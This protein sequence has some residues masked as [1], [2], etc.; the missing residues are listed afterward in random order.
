M[1]NNKINLLTA[2]IV[3]DATHHLN[4][5]PMP[6]FD[7]TIH[8]WISKT[9][10]MGIG[11][12]N[13]QLYNYNYQLAN[14]TQRYEE[15]GEA[16]EPREM[17]EPN[18]YVQF[19][20]LAGPCLDVLK[21]YLSNYGGYRRRQLASWHQGREEADYAP[22]LYP[23]TM[24][25]IK[26][27]S[28]ESGDIEI[29]SQYGEE[30]LN[31]FDGA[32]DLTDL[33][34]PLTLNLIPEIAKRR[35][36]NARINRYEDYEKAE[37]KID[38]FG[39]FSCFGSSLD[40]EIFLQKA[41]TDNCK[42]IHLD[43][44]Y[45]GGSSKVEASLKSVKPQKIVKGAY[46]FPYLRKLQVMDQQTLEV[47][48]IL[49]F[50]LGMFDDLEKIIKYKRS[51]AFLPQFVKDLG[52]AG[53][54][55]Y[56]K[57]QE[58]AAHMQ[59]TWGKHI[60][61]WEG[62]SQIWDD[63]S[64]EAEPLDK[65]LPALVNSSHFAFL[66]KAKDITKSSEYVSYSRVRDAYQ[67]VKAKIK[68]A[69]DTIVNLERNNTY[70]VDRI[71]EL[72][73]E[74]VRK[75]E[76]LQDAEQT[77]HEAK[78]NILS[79]TPAFEAL[80]K[81]HEDSKEKYDSYLQSVSSLDAS[82]DDKLLGNS[83]SFFNNIAEMGI[84]IKRVVYRDNEND[85]SVELSD[86][87]DVAFHAK[88]GATYQDSYGNDCKKYSFQSIEFSLDKPVIIRVDY[89]SKGENCK[90][91]VGGPYNCVLTSTDLRVSLKSTT[92]CFGLNKGV[93]G[94]STVWV[95]PHT[96]GFSIHANE[97]ATFSRSFVDH[98]GR[99]CLGEASSAVYN[100]FSNQDPKQAIF[101]AMSWLTNANSSDQWGKNWKYFP[102]LENVNL[103][104]SNEIV[105]EETAEEP[106]ADELVT[107]EEG[108]D[109][110]SEMVSDLIESLDDLPEETPFAE[111]LAVEP[112][113]LDQNLDQLTRAAVATLDSQSNASSIEA[114]RA[115][116]PELS[117]TDDPPALLINETPG[118]SPILAQPPQP[119]ATV[120]PPN[121]E[122]AVA[123]TAG[124]EGY[125]SLYSLRASKSQEPQAEQEDS[126]EHQDSEESNAE[127]NFTSDEICNL[128]EVTLDLE[129]HLADEPRFSF[130]HRVDIEDQPVELMPNFR[131][132]I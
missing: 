38:T 33:D 52:V 27:V 18:N 53:G 30:V 82:K 21:S 55:K 128:S 94:Y 87:P 85:Y 62:M 102:L 13:C 131:E 98:V 31:Y 10:G 97:W 64:P 54:M 132:T 105:H 5:L 119:T 127:T 99:A 86:Q 32:I 8:Q 109:F 16:Q 46:I 116:T 75:K 29:Y 44:L 79:Y 77:L 24:K 76:S 35:N 12:M 108:M 19:V 115:A 22:L 114:F 34:L 51:R 78:D 70:I 84:S 113:A 17:H 124:V 122:T 72:E 120:L 130:N 106:S 41:G 123:A 81:E 47:K 48:N 103:D 28:T 37:V 91:I 1:E 118:L 112:Q 101:A 66:E 45:R 111:T 107:S 121:R 11:L 73:R 57:P 36:P 69:E 67:N 58:Y 110:L 80:G 61:H 104:G 126:E 20:K 23:L 7:G 39:S 100:A 40:K 9:F 4:R 3:T 129:E 83:R 2:R 95:H 89:G 68:N 26:T 50:C 60:V 63:I 117:P 74:L 90:K 42:V 14:A 71:A 92:A 96:A 93:D 59:K 25:T 125:S 56:F 15:H 6:N 49:V 65:E 88:N 43:F